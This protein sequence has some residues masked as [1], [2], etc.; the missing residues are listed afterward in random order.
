V[1]STTVEMAV[2]TEAVFHHRGHCIRVQS[3]TRDGAA[4]LDNDDGLSPNYLVTSALL[5]AAADYIDSLSGDP[6]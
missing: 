5:R 4:L 2:R 3:V 1:A 6:K